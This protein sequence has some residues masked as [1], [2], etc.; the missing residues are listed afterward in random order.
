MTTESHSFSGQVSKISERISRPAVLGNLGDRYNGPVPEA[1]AILA[2][3]RTGSDTLDIARTLGVPE[4][5]IYS[6]LPRVLEQSRQDRE[7]TR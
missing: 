7:W 6:Q 4:S 5:Y 1:R 2:L 3:W